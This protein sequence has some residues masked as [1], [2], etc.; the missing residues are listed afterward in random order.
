MSHKEFEKKLILPNLYLWINDSLPEPFQILGCDGLFRRLVLELIH[1]LS[2]LIK[3]FTLEQMC[4]PDNCTNGASL[5]FRNVATVQK[6]I[7]RRA[8]IGKS[9][10]FTGHQCA[11]VKYVR[12]Y[13]RIGETVGPSLQEW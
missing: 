13:G 5:L 11:E 4:L 10:A 12:I 2:K 1:Q 8:L 7:P 3:S 6:L 9:A